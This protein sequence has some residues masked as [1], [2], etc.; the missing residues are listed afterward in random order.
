MVGLSENFNPG[1]AKPAEERRLRGAAMVRG[2][3]KGESPLFQALA[4]GLSKLTGLVQD[5]WNLVEDT[6][7][8]G[9]A[10]MRLPLEGEEESLLQ[11]LQTKQLRGSSLIPPFHCTRNFFFIIIL[12]TL[13]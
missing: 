3:S 4:G 9:K 12:P 10:W 5:S 1:G 2:G 11:G 7:G 13:N 6:G 8:V